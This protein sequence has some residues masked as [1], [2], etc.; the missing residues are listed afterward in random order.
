LLYLHILF[1]TFSY[2]LLIN[3]KKIKKMHFAYCVALDDALVH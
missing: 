3:K 1:V 2:L